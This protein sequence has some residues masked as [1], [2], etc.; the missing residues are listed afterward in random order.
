MATAAL[1]DIN[2][3]PRTRV[4]RAQGGFPHGTK[5]RPAEIGAQIRPPH[6]RIPVGIHVQKLTHS[7]NGSGTGR[8]KWLTARDLYGDNY[9][10]LVRIECVRNAGPFDRE[11][12]VLDSSEGNLQFETAELEPG[13][14]QV[15]YLFERR[16]LDVAAER[17]GER[18]EKNSNRCLHFSPLCQ[19]W[20]QGAVRLINKARVGSFRRIGRD[21]RPEPAP[22]TFAETSLGDGPHSNYWNDPRLRDRVA[23]VIRWSIEGQHLPLGLSIGV[24]QE[25]TDN[26]ELQVLALK[27]GNYFGAVLTALLGGGLLW[28]TVLCSFASGHWIAELA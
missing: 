17:A 6:R 3:Y 8:P 10:D 19:T 11:G 25:L 28:M 14:R 22:P 13:H 1:D 4:Q 26:E 23:Q 2:P 16:R 20:R 21:L 15:V 18:Q 27:P 9:I 12:P 7:P 24:D 5:P